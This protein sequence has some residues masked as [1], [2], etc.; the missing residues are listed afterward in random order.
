MALP[1]RIMSKRAI[2]KLRSLKTLTKGTKRYLSSTVLESENGSHEGVI[3]ATQENSSSSESSFPSIL[4]NSELPQNYRFVYPEFLPDPNPLYRNALRERLERM[5]MLARRANISIPEFYVGSILA[6]IY[7]EPHA[8]GK[9]NKFVGICINREKCGLRANFLLRNVVDNQ[10]IEVLFELYD[11]AIQHIDCLRCEKRLDNRLF[12]LRDA[13]LEYSTFPFDMEKQILHEGAEIPIN[14]I[15]VPLNPPPWLEKWNRQ[16]LKGVQKLTVSLRQRL[17]AEAAAKPWE[18]YDLMKIYRSTIP[19]EEQNEI[20]SEMNA[21]I[22]QLEIDR[23]RQ[24]RKHAFDS[25]TKK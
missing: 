12:Y 19:E 3:S 16:D 4:Q 22:R 11:P 23:H 17:K 20:F 5:D 6:V 15:K 21:E 18:K 2:Q 13:P 10:G 24:K 1:L 9:V 14:D 25:K 7:T 8:P